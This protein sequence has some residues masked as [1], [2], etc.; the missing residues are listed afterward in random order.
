MKTKIHQ[1]EV[2]WTRQSAHYTRVFTFGE[3]RLK[4]S[5]KVDSY[6]FQSYA[7]LLRWNGEEWKTVSIVPYSKMK[8]FSELGHVKPA[9]GNEAP[10]RNKIVDDLARLLNDAEYM[11]GE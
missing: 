1:S 6:R 7:K 9:N 4:I 10:F 5:I 2:Y 8:S 3:H 11:F